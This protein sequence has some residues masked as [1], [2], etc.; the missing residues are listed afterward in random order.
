MYIIRD[1]RDNMA[2][3]GRTFESAREAGQTCLALNNSIPAILQDEGGFYYVEYIDDDNDL[4]SSNSWHCVT[5]NF[6]V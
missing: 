5:D 6:I 2:L 3:Q 4:P 1:E